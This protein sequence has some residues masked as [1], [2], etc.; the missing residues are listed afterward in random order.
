[1]FNLEGNYLI[2]QNVITVE[3]DREELPIVSIGNNF[4]GL[5]FAIIKGKDIKAITS[6]HINGSKIK[7]SSEQNFITFDS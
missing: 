5:Q 2:L 1:M 3:D 7:E 6:L 4:E